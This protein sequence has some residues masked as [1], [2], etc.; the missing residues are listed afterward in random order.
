MALDFDYGFRFTKIN[1]M[2]RCGG[3][4]DEVALLVYGHESGTVV[5]CQEAVQLPSMET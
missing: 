4:E 3:C 5:D 2:R 1:E